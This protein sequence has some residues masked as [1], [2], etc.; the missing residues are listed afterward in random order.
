METITGD[1]LADA[2]AQWVSERL[3]CEKVI[4]LYCVHVTHEQFHSAEITLG[5]MGV[6]D[7][8]RNQSDSGLVWH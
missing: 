2:S 6:T 4:A 1:R 8:G 3:S 5:G 7:S